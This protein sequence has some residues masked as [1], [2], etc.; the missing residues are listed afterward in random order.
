MF[1]MKRR[2][3][4][5][6]LG[7]A[8]VSPLDARAQQPGR[9]PRVGFL[10]GQAENDPDAQTSL[11]AFLQ[12]LQEL[13]WIDGRT[14]R[15]DYR[16]GAGDAGLISTYAAEL[17]A[18]AP[19]VILAT[20]GSTM[21]PLQHA[22]AAVPIVFVQ[23]PDPVGAGFVASL[24]QPSGNATGFTQSEFGIRA[25]WLDGVIGRPACG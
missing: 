23:V 15:I 12:A 25:K 18:R 24:A 1:D 8:A 3:F 5:A 10:T 13:G 9:M 21:G 6:M 2:E 7:S 19:D 16:W 20:G 11:A 17:I 14:V 4:I 22:S